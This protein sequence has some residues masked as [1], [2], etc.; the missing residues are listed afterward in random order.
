MATGTD[1]VVDKQ[2]SWDTISLHDRIWRVVLIY[3]G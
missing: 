3:K 1:E 2:A